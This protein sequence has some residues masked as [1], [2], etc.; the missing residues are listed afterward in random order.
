MSHPVLDY[1]HQLAIPERE[2]ICQRCGTTWA[3]IRK[4]CYAGQQLGAVI[5]VELEKQTSGALPVETTFPEVDWR[6]VRAR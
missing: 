6:Y 2:R 5:C 4:A 3:Y 1:F